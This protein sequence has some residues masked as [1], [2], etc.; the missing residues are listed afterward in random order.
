MI[1]DTK[2]LCMLEHRTRLQPHGRVKEK[3][4]KKKEKKQLCEQTMVEAQAGMQTR[5]GEEEALGYQEMRP[6]MGTV[7]YV[8]L[9]ARP[10]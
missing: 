8:L 2:A 1:L 3:K 5:N 6:K 9:S 10:L 4:R 7:I